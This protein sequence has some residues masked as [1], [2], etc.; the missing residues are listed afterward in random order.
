MYEVEKFFKETI[1][2]T[3]KKE[4]YGKFEIQIIQKKLF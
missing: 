2:E 1:N 4:T 3:L